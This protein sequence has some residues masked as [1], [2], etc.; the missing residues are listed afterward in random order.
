MAIISLTV[1]SRQQWEGSADPSVPVCPTDPSHRLVK[2]GQ[3]TRHADSLPA[4]ATLVVQRYYCRAC[5]TRY[6]ALPYDLRPYSTAT[7]G[8][9]LAV[10]V[11]WR[12]EHGWTVEA[13][14]RWLEAHG[15]PYHRRTLERWKAR[16]QTALPAIIQAA[17]QWIAQ[18]LGT[19]ALAVFPGHD[20]PPWHHW[21]RLWRDVRDH[22]G[23]DPAARRGGW[24]GTSVLW[25]WM[26]IT[27]FA[28][29]SPG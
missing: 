23:S 15:L 5:A 4:D 13:C 25:N 14:H 6:S 24:L 22:L 11:V 9:T 27:F 18:H 28:G 16:W 8:V 20:E 17:V 21:R 12:T 26:P 2:D 10:G 29:L 7:W 19:R 3:Y 1:S